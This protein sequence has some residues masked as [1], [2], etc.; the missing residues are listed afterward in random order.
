MGR[1]MATIHICCSTFK[2]TTSRKLSFEFSRDYGYN[3]QIIVICRLLKS[4][5]YAYNRSL[6]AH[7][8]LCERKDHLPRKVTPIFIYFDYR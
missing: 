2:R 6:K 7:V 8:F 3:P 1:I 5:D 4:A